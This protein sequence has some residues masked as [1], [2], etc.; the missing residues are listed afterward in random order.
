M[1]LVFKDRVVEFPHRYTITENGDGTITLTPA[2]GNIVQEGTPLNANNLMTLRQLTDDTTS[3][4]Y[5]LGINN[6]L[7]YYKEVIE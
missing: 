3:K 6:G 4:T 7:L 1:S 2:P 5:E